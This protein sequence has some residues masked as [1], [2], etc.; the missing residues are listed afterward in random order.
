[1]RYCSGKARSEFKTMMALLSLSVI[2]TN[3]RIILYMERFSVVFI[4]SEQYHQISC[5]TQAEAAA[6]LKQVFI[7]QDKEPIGIYDAK[8][9]LFDWEPVQKHQYDKLGVE[10][11]GRL[12][13]H[14]ISIA[15]TL[16]QQEQQRQEPGII[17]EPIFSTLINGL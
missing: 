2:Q 11:Q 17:Q 10:E 4:S 14:L 3:Q 15:Q 5:A 7:D 8:T 1:M 6:M 13:N 16:R 9:E 12:G